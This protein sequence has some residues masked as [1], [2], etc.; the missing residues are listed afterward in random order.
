MKLRRRVFVLLMGV[1]AGVVTG[2]L[3]RRPA[4]PPTA[5]ADALE[6][7][8]VVPGTVSATPSGHQTQADPEGF[9]PPGPPGASST[10]A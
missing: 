8:A 4:A 10:S 2:V 9:S 6:A 7:D 1:V 3:R 5:E